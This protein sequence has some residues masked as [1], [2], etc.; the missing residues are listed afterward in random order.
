M[1][2]TVNDDLRRAYRTTAFIGL[3]M[4]ACLVVFAAVVEFI[5][6]RHAPFRGYSP[7]PDA[8]G[9]LRYAFLCA[10][11]VEFF[12]IRSLNRLIL[13]GRAP[14]R[15]APAGRFAPEVQRLVSAS[16][17]A[18]VLCESVAVYGIVLFLIQG[19][20]GDFYLFL[21]LSLFSFSTYFPRYGAWKTWVA[22]REQER[23]GRPRP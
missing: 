16:I 22:E 4:M 8:I 7:L 15:D 14:L 3:A 19:N 18:Y 21:V 11:A 17:V 1:R 10:V 2:Q 5:K 9:T 6:S 13:Y 23:A 12:A 20:S